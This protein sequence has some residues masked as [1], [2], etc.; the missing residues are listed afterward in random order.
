MGLKCFFLNRIVETLPSFF[1]NFCIRAGA[2]ENPGARA[3]P[4]PCPARVAARFRPAAFKEQSGC[5]YQHGSNTLYSFTILETDVQY[6]GNCF[7]FHTL[8]RFTVISVI[9]VKLRLMVQCH[10]IFDLFVYFAEISK[11]EIFNSHSA[12]RV[13]SNF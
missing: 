7:T 1:Y 13:K 5:L 9:Q 11:F 4:Q 8:P 6:I 12:Q 2:G 10:K 3:A